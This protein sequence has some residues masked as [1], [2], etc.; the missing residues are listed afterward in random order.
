MIC[1]DTFYY[2]TPPYQV[3][4]AILRVGRAERYQLTSPN[5]NPILRTR[6]FQF[7]FPPSMEPSTSS[8]STGRS[9]GKPS[10]AARMMHRMVMAMKMP[11]PGSRLLKVIL[12]EDEQYWVDHQ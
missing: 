7:I 4:M 9:S 6:K 1:E 8:I 3:Y 12:G 2:R 11:P 5:S 10:Q